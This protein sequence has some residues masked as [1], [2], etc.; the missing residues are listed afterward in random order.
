METLMMESSMVVAAEK[1][2][3]TLMRKSSWVLAAQLRGKI[4][5]AISEMMNASVVDEKARKNCLTE[6]NTALIISHLDYTADMRNKINNT[7]IN[8]DDLTNAQ[9]IVQEIVFTELCNMLDPPLV[10]SCFVPEKGKTSVIIFVGLQGSRGKTTTCTKYA[11]YYQK[12]KGLKAGLVV[13]AD[14]CTD[15]A[16]AFDQ[17]KQNAT[18]ANIPVYG[19]CYMESD[20]VKIAV[21]GVEKF[22]EENCDLIILDTTWRHKQRDILFQ[23]DALFEELRQISDATKPDLVIFVIDTRIGKSDFVEAQAFK[24]SVAVGAIIITKVAGHAISGDSVSAVAATKSPVIF[25][26]T[27]EHMD[28]FQVFQVK[29]F[30]SRLLEMGDSSEFVDTTHVVIIPM[31]ER[32]RKTRELFEHIG[33]RTLL[34]RDLLPPPPPTTISTGTTPTNRTTEF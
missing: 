4:S 31:D 5:R 19:S 9:E 18:K 34:P 23:D 32:S 29:P 13:C 33:F 15:C 24:Q 21:E 17:L 8:L 11:N 6:I 20:P 10:N 3:E 30:V 2:M 1:E 28:E 27:G 7:I 22:K 16:E 25:V 14:T 12:N 26:G